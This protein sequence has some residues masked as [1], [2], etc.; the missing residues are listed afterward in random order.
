MVSLSQPQEV[1]LRNVVVLAGPPGSVK[2]TFCHRAVPSALVVDRPVTFVTTE[3]GPSEITNPLREEGMGEL[4][5]VA[6]QVSSMPSVK[7]WRRQHQN[8]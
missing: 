8:G 1:P 3:H 4:L 5:P 6:R 2:S 7:L